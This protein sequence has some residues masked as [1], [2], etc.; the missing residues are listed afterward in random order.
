MVVSGA[1]T[2]NG[3][4]VFT[5]ANGTKTFN[6]VTIAAGAT[7]DCSGYDM[8]FTFSGDLIN[9]GT[10]NASATTAGPNEYKFT[11]ATAA[12][13]GT[14]TIPN[15]NVANGAVLTNTNTLAITDSLYGSGK[16][17]QGT[18]ATLLY[19]SGK[20]ITVST[21]NPSATGNLVDYDYAGDQ[22]VFRTTR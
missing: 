17:V 1:T 4:I 7:W 18:G 22:T 19:N 6:T 2:D 13:A 12:I 3:D 11:S 8:H 5:N 16:F 9:N 20:T 10:F 14:L 21:F 15:L